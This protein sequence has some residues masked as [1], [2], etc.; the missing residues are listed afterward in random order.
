MIGPLIYHYWIKVTDQ[1]RHLKTAVKKW[2][3]K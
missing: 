3:G 1:W 2:W